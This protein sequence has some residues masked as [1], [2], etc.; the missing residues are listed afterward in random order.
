MFHGSVSLKHNG[1]RGTAQALVDGTSKGSL[2]ARDAFARTNRL[3]IGMMF[4]RLS[5]RL[6]VYLERVCVVITRFTLTRI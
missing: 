4:V 5:V 3:A 1:T 2:L 6:S